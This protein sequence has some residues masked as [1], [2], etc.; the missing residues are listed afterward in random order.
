MFCLNIA[1]NYCPYCSFAD[2]FFRC[3]ERFFSLDQVESLD[4]VFIE[5]LYAHYSQFVHVLLW[6]NEYPLFFKRQIISHKFTF[7]TNMIKKI[8]PSSDILTTVTAWAAALQCQLETVGRS[9]SNSRSMKQK[10]V[11]TWTPG[12]CIYCASQ[13]NGPNPIRQPHRALPKDSHTTTR[14]LPALI[15]SK[16]K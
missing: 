8:C 15:K 1:F 13:P 14:V 5:T 16:W 10:H 9:N 3:A 4:R 12:H 2:M 6:F 11:P 7:F